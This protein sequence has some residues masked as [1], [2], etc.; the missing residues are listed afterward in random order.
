[1][2][3]FLEAHPVRNRES[4]GCLAYGCFRESVAARHRHHAIAG[5][6]SI[7][8]L[9]DCVDNARYFRSGNKRKRRFDLI[10]APD[11]K[12][13]EK[14]ERRGAI[15]DSDFAG[16]RRGLRDVVEAHRFRLA[17]LMHPPRSHSMPACVTNL[18]IMYESIAPGP[19]SDPKPESL[20]PP[21]GTSGRAKPW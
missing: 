5:T 8:A 6:E 12:N 3:A 9:A 13:V 15:A 18:L 16:T 17:P 21:N 11:L 7:D 20:I 19:L 14:V 4:G 2:R 10:L 1:G